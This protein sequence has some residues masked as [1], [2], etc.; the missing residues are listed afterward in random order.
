MIDLGANHAVA[1]AEVGA[2]ESAGDRDDAVD[3]KVEPAGGQIEMKTCENPVDEN[4]KLGQE[5]GVQG[6]PTIIVDDGRVVPGY[7]PAAEIIS[8]L[9]LGDK[10]ESNKG[11]AK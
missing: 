2:Q 11:V 3:E 4:Q 7:A 9:G 10:S 6:T 5:V 1:L 8:A